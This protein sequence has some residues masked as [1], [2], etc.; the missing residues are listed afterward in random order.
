MTV[1]QR[2]FKVSIVGMFCSLLTLTVILILSFTYLKNRE[3]LIDFV[4]QRFEAGSSAVIDKATAYMQS[5]QSLAEISTKLLEEPNIDLEVESNLGF[6]LMEAVM[7][8]PHVDLFYFGNESGQFLQAADLGSEIYSK[9]ITRKDGQASTFFQYYD[10]DLNRTKTTLKEQEEYDPRKRP[11]YKG[12]KSTKSTYWSDPYIFFENGKP[13]I[14]VAAPVYSRNDELK[15]VLGVDITL[16]GLSDFLQKMDLSP[17]SIAMIFDEHGQILAYPEPEKMMTV[18]N[19]EIRNVRPHELGVPWVTH[20]VRRYEDQKEPFFSYTEGHEKYLARFSPFPDYFGKDWTLAIMAP[21][22]DF[23]GKAKSILQITLWISAGVLLIAILIGLALSKKL[24]RPIEVLSLEILKVGKFELDNQITIKTPIKEIQDM[25]TAISRMK[26]GL[27]AFQRYVP[28][29]L[30]KELVVSGEDASLGGR[31]RELTI[32]FSDIAGFTSIT[33]DTPPRDLMIQLSEYFDPII[34]T[35]AEE[36]GTLDK[37]IGDAVMAFWGAPTINDD[38]AYSA[39]RTALRCQEAVHRLNEIW[40]DKGQ[41]PFNTRIGLHTG[42]CIVGNIGSND[43]MNYSVLGDNVNLASRLEGVNK[44]Y[45]TEIIIS[46]NTHRY[47]KN[48]FICR[49]LDQITVMGK[50]QSEQI[51]E[52][53]AEDTEDVPQELKSFAETF[54]KAYRHYTQREWQPALDLFEESLSYRPEDEAGLG[55]IKQCQEFVTRNPHESWTPITRIDEK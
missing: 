17:N 44:L 20:A 51:Y 27:R 54:N 25:E 42:Y 30:V 6:Y 1:R 34:K 47:I 35:I 19:G 43:R 31:D 46:R 53:L 55:Y 4:S 10:R 48:N 3:A 49:I 33:E 24:S 15:G 23:L 8:H 26:N 14:T 50:T 5:A 9:S 28:A 21:E 37:F 16:E 41:Q 12:A 11:W 38:H 32:F 45:G 40:V 13:G 18:E 36:K 2:S 39:C 52:L 22:D 29:S 7:I